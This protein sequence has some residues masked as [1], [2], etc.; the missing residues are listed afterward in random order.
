MKEWEKPEQDDGSL[1]TSRGWIMVLPSSPLLIIM[2][3]YL[4]D[5]INFS[6]SS[7]NK[8]ILD[9]VFFYTKCIRN[10]T[11]K[12]KVNLYFDLVWSFESVS[13]FTLFRFNIK[14]IY[15]LQSSYTWRYLNYFTIIFHFIGYNLLLDQEITL[16]INI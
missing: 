5:L 1:I 16:A 13:S 14:S 4:Y 12:R 15:N 2:Q 10:T 8:I 11:T 9:Y 3:Q 6:S 7:T